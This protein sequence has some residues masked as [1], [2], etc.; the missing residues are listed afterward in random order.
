[1]FKTNVGG[2]DRVL[3]IVVGLVLLALFFVYPDA[4][5]RYYT[6]IGI[7]PLLTGLLSTCPLYSIIGVSTCP[8]KRA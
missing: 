1:M 5:W 3:R 6:L 4:P 2:I 8:A 7:V